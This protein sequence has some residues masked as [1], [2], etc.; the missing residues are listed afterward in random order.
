G[1]VRNPRKKFSRRR[2]GS[3]SI[4][5][6]LVVVR[7]SDMNASDVLDELLER[8]EELR[9]QGQQPAPEELC[10]DTPHLLGELRTRITALCPVES[11]L[12]RPG[13]PVPGEGPDDSPLAAEDGL[14]LPSYVFLEKIGRGGMGVVYKAWDVELK[15]LVAVKL[16]LG[17]Y[18][19]E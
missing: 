15:R 14:T 18:L 7:E 4:W 2:S 5:E 3:F 16:L 11:L 1:F 12:H 10:K 19:S 8:W 6:A 17:R 13:E 9:R